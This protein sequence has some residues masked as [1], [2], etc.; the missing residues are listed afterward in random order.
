MYYNK[1]SNRKRIVTGKAGKT[2]FIV[3]IS[4]AINVVFFSVEGRRVGCT[5]Y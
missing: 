3:R 5:K 1:C 2:I 4:H